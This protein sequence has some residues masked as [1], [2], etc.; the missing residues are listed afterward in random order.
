M[1]TF[2]D[3]KF[4]HRG[5][6]HFTARIEFPNGYGAS[7]VRG[8]GTYGGP[9]GLYELAVLHGGIIAYDTPITD[10]VLG[11]LTEGDVTERLSEVETLPPRRS[12][13]GV[14]DRA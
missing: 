2:S 14:A 3:L 4:S 11:W 8:P 13:V 5:G 6:G 12:E 10:D 9:E 7:V 1:A